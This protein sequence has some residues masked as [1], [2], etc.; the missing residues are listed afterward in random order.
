MHDS[1]NQL[2]RAG[3]EVLHE[4]IAPVHVSGHACQEELRTMLS[5][6]RPRHVMPIH[7]EY[8]MLAAHAKL[9]R[10]AGVP[11]ERILIAE[12]GSVVE[13]A[14]G[15]ARLVDKVD[16]GVT[17][18]DGLRVG[19]VRDVAL[20]DRRRLADDGVLIV[21]TTLASSDGGEIAPPELISRGFAE[22][23][24]PHR[25]A[26]GGGGPGRQR[27]RVRARD[28]DQ[29]P[30]GA[31]PRRGRPDRLRPNAPPAHGA[32]RR[33]RGLA[34]SGWAPV[35]EGNAAT[36]LTA[37]RLVAQ[38]RACEA[39]SLAFCRLLERWGRGEAVPSTP[40]AREAALR[41]AADRVE[42]ALA[43]L[44][45]PLSRYLLELEPERAEGRSWYAG[46]GAGELVEWQPVLDRAGVS[47]CPNR[48]AAVYLELAVLV[49]ALEGLATA[50]RMDA[51]PDRSSLWAGL[52]DL[53]DTLL[54]ST[55]DDLRALAA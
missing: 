40:G 23:G 19:D 12:N 29:A 31:H 11:E 54:G 41:R 14:R 50:A 39:A 5:L 38:L 7:G 17:F 53:R 13:L 27:A 6:L 2:A 51:A 44:E 52:F 47:A 4:E 34:L 15:G 49:R 43:G 25:R 48:V 32:P 35:I 21:V 33:D 24:R 36:E 22:L 8:R 45:R 9:A 18:V 37:R 20:R 28:G 10:D 55:V 46:P 42:T 26:P 30:P 3:A 1:I 16:A